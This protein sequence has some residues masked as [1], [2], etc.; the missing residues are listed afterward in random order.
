[1]SL[2]KI[3]SLSKK[4]LGKKIS[5]SGWVENIRDHGGVIFIDLREGNEILQVVVEPQNKEI[6][7]IAESIR[8]EF[9]ISVSGEIKERPKGTINKKMIT[10]EIE[11]NS[12]NLSILS[13]SKPMP[14]QLD[15]YVKVGEETRLKYRY[16]DLRRSEMQET[17][18]IR[19]KVSNE[20]RQF[21]ISNDF[22][23]I[24]TPMMT[25]ATPEGARD[26]VIPSRVNQGSFYALPQS[27]QLFKQLLMISGFGK[28]FQ[29]VRCFRDEDTRKDRQPEFTQID[30]ESSFT[31]TEEV[32]DL[33]ENLIKEVFK[34]ILNI[35]LKD[36]P[37]MTYSEAI[38]KFGSDKPDL[39]NPLELIDVK[40]IFTDSE[41]KVF[42]D[43]A[44]D[45]KSRL[46]ALK[47][48]NS[49]AR[50]QIDDYTKFV[51]N[52]GAKGLAYIKVNDA[53]DLKEGLQSPILKFLSETEIE[54][55]SKKLDISTG[56][57][58]FFGAGYKKIVNE[59]MGAL[60][61]KLGADL[62]LIDKEKWAPLWIKD[63][64]VFDEAEDGS[65]SPSHHPFTRTSD[66]LEMLEKNPAMAIADAYDLVLNGYEIGGGSMRIH[67]S[68]EQRKVL[69][70][71]GISEEAAEEKFGFFLEALD[72]GC[73]P[74]GGIAFGLDRL[75]MLICNKDSIRDVIA[76]PKTQ[77]AYCLMTDAPSNISDDELKELAIK[78]TIQ[79]KD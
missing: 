47:I 35:E 59:S 72:Y 29:I 7:E 15:E 50:S 22:L 23:D 58:V 56:D 49:L 32:M 21:L 60:R 39:R 24:E 40:D 36:F 41:F 63:F 61:E 13:K 18:R 14:F 76:F 16:L 68:E 62:N 1:M 48:S 31:S 67:N 12:S 25:K 65:L 70:I 75:V 42:G 64:P 51:G 57:T 34:N 78:S 10:G 55:L 17:I 26:F 20:I 11:L 74:H 52:Y 53:N 9:V 27:P 19:S 77:S 28:Y 66:N 8:N 3:S 73:P 46:V 44:K 45:A 37:V 5:V 33:G 6:F 30:I 38:K 71:L 54:S 43:P 79:P 4:N 69:S 2:L